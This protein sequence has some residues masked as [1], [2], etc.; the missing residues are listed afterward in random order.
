VTDD[1]TWRIVWEGQR[2]CS[3]VVFQAELDATLSIRET[4]TYNMAGLIIRFPDGTV[5]DNI[6]DEFS[7]LRRDEDDCA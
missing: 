5:E 1:N 7:E 3:P 2:L 4:T 6:I